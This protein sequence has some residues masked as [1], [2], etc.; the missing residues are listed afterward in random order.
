MLFFVVVIRIKCDLVLISCDTI[1]N[2]SLFPLLDC[3]R[4]NNASIVV[5]LFKGGV[6][7]DAVVPGPKAKHKQGMIEFVSFE[8]VDSIGLAKERPFTVHLWCMESD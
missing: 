5:Q 7:A 6:E 3:F 1:T 8:R 4:N 2:V